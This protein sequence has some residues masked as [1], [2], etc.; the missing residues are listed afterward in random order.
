MAA[1]ERIL[2]GLPGLDAALDSIR[3][4]DNV[5]FQLTNMEDYAF[6][7]RP[8]VKQ[9]VA[10]RRQIVYFRFAEHPPL[11]QEQDGLKIIH[12]D[13]DTG[14]ESFTVRVHEVIAEEGVG[15]FYVFDCLSELQTIW[16]TDLMMGNFFLVTC[17][18]LFELD[19]VAYFGLLRNKHSFEI[20]A[21]I[22]ET[23]QLLLDVFS[24]GDD[25]YVH[26]LK[27]WYRY[28]QSMFLPHK[29]EG[30]QGDRLLPLTDG[31]NASKFYGLVGS[32][33]TLYDQTLDNWDRVFLRARMELEAGLSDCE[34][35]LGKMCRMLIGR[36]PQ[37]TEL[38]KSQFSIG[39]F[40]RIKERM[41]GSGSIGG[42]AAGMLLARK[43]LEN[44]RPDLA[45]R[46][47]PHDSFYIGSDVFYAFLVENGWWK[48]RIHQ[49]TD[50]G[51]FTAA[52]E[53][54]EK[55]MGGHFPEGVRERFR[56][57]LE[58]YGQQ[59]I[60]VRSS[61]LLEDSFGNAFAG[62]YE[63]VFC[64]N[65]GTFEQ[66]FTAF[67]K[68]IREV[69]AS[70]MDESALIYRQ[71]RGLDKNDEQMAILVQRVSG[72]LFDDIFMPCAAG[73]GYSYNSY[74]WNQE[75]QP[76]AG[77]VRI[78]AGLGTRAVDRTDGDYPRIAALDKPM[79]RP[80]SSSSQ[81]Y[82]FSQRYVDILHQATNRQTSM[83]I[84]QLA[85]K[86]P[87]WYKQL[88]FEHDKEA[89]ASL[90][91]RGMEREVLFTTCQM[92]LEN[93]MLVAYLKDVLKTVESIYRYP[94]DMEFTL[95]FSE[96]G[97]FV[98]NLLQCRPLQVGGLGVRVELP[99]HIPE[100]TLFASQGG[101][102]GGSMVLPV[103][104]VIHVDSKNYY[105][106]DMQVK[107]EVARTIGMINSALR[108]TGK[109]IML[110]GPGR[111]GTSSPE[112]GVPVR[113]AEISAVKVLC[114]VSYEGAGYMP[115]LS[116]GSHFFQDL[117]ETGIFYASMFEDKEDSLYHPELLQDCTNIFHDLVPEKTSL[118]AIISVYATT[119]RRL[120]LLSDTISQKTLC[121]ME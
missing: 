67:E 1:F 36:E 42:K 83:V 53:L 41:A 6:F 90:R 65:S 8:F 121:F 27:V 76:E 4:G 86:V 22:R 57:I 50:S 46:L 97:D 64:V 82:R 92:I 106:S 78:V 40:L 21:R 51:Y 81:S 63:S 35:K 104:V 9:A 89:E 108:G 116:F 91:E 107:Y 98:F 7:V 5:V 96:K 110:I 68:A 72:S 77:L 30:P 114:E 25:M 105:L 38:V 99:A 66:R 54:K 12:V 56:R 24:E 60:I 109:S 31:I 2:S 100:K 43:I 59:P 16:S 49:R 84:D 32:Q 113:F 87:E 103:D 17:P 45:A 85:G 88:F 23:T 52:A 62:K 93:R 29:F 71:A 3:L 94:V 11:L 34:D 79:L 70:A 117:V 13:P 118:S 55:I 58:Y 119:E 20:I 102:M 33:G 69:Y 101:T 44:S 73:V 28:S 39:D 75:I 80:V 19:T 120:S 61:S 18:Y 95:N 37:L 47:E 14:F 74:V 115:E 111:W 26:P 15:A 10:D 48:L 112:L